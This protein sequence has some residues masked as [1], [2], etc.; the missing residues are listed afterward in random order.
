MIS[1]KIQNRNLDGE[2]N[3]EKPERTTLRFFVVFPSLIRSLPPAI[4]LL[5]YFLPSCDRVHAIL[6]LTMPVRPSFRQSSR[7]SVCRSDGTFGHAVRIHSKKLSYLKIWLCPT[8]R[9]RYC[10]VFG[11]V[12]PFHALFLLFYF[13]N[14]PFFVS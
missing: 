5:F 12:Y 9:D 13:G 1:I 7:P 14:C 8:A 3:W 10:R 4:L 2:R 11:L 6:K